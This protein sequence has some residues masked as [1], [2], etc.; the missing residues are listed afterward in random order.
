MAVANVVDMMKV[1][2]YMVMNPTTPD[3]SSRSKGGTEI[4]VLEDFELI[5]IET[6]S[7]LEAEEY[8]THV[9][10]L[11]TLRGWAGAFL[12]RSHDNDAYS[13]VYD[14]GDLVTGTASGKTLIK[15]ALKSGGK[16]LTDRAKK[17]L[18]VPDEPDQHPGV[19]FM[20]AILFPEEA[21][22]IK[23]QLNIQWGFPLVFKGF[24][25]ADGFS[26]QWGRLED[27]TV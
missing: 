21:A 25:D 10:G 18:F 24:P 2:G 26:V 8:N 23:H 27:M 11:V 13:A 7:Y 3:S 15:P 4:G 5:P 9:N 17:F 19:L 12:L 6:H 16:W 20:N 1:G 22:R 14:S